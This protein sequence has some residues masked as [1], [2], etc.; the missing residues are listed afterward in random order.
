MHIFAYVHFEPRG[1]KIEFDIIR[2]EHH[3]TRCDV[4]PSSSRF[5]THSSW[6]S[7]NTAVTG[8]RHET[9]FGN[10]L[11]TR[12]RRFTSRFVRSMA[13]EILSFLQVSLGKLYTVKPSSIHH[14]S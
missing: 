13:F 12:V 14:A 3:F 6:I 5:T 9:S 1:N 11:A 2:M 10:K 4:D 8:R 7:C